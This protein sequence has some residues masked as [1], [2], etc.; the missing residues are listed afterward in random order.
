MNRFDRQTII[1]EIGKQGQEKL[2]NSTVL[3]IGAGG[4]GSPVLTYL[5]AAGV[6]KSK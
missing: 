3:V 4:L 5:S 2:L 6:E 1:P